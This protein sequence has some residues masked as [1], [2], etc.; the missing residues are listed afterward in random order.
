MWQPRLVQVCIHI[1]H[2]HIILHKVTVKLLKH[3][4]S[5]PTKTSKFN[6]G[7]TKM[8]EKLFKN[9]TSIDE[10]NVH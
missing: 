1:L 4:K 5:L 9:F 7:G 6:C 3:A 8:K 2:R 10:E